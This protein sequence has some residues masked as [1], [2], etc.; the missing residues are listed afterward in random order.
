MMVTN[1]DCLKKCADQDIQFVARLVQKKVW[2]LLVFNRELLRCQVKSW[3]PAPLMRWQMS[4]NHL[5]Q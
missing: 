2:G 3:V 1:Y 5:S 4:V